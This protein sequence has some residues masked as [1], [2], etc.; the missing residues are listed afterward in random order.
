MRRI[1]Q[2]EN[3]EAETRRR[4]R[5]WQRKLQRPLGELEMQ[6]TD[7]YVIR[8]SIHRTCRHALELVACSES[9]STAE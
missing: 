9:E 5:I 1:S 6:M 2:S 4:L 7:C 3:D 8:R